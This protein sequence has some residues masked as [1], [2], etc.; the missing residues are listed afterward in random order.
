MTIFLDNEK[1]N[2]SGRKNVFSVIWD[3]TGLY[4]IMTY[5]AVYS[6]NI[7]F[8]VTNLP[9]DRFTICC[10]I[11][12]IFTFNQNVDIINSL[13]AVRADS[14]QSITVRGRNDELAMSCTFENVLYR[15]VF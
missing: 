7:K 9:S 4:T 1:S 10:L 6:I 5:P 3:Y 12:T 13:T 8:N 2:L 14:P 15:P 11:F